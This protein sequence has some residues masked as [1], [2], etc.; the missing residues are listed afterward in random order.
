MRVQLYMIQ[1]NTQMYPL[2]KLGSFKRFRSELSD[3]DTEP[4][5]DISTSN[6]SMLECMM[7]VKM[8]IHQRQW[9]YQGHSE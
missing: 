7:T 1:T 9:L 6:E 5:T 3:S 8:K 4:T 2:D